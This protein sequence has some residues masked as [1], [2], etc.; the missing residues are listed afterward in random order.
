MKEKNLSEEFN[1]LLFLTGICYT[2][3]PVKGSYPLLEYGTHLI[4]NIIDFVAKEHEKLG[5]KNVRFNILIPL[6]LLE[7]MKDFY[8]KFAPEAFV[9][10]ET[11]KGQKF[12][13]PLVL[14]ATSEIPMYHTYSKIIRSYRD[15]P[16]K[17]YQIVP[18]FRCETKMTRPL[19]R[20]REIQ[21][22][23]EAHAFF[24]N[25]DQAMEEFDKA[26]DLYKRIYEYFNIPYIM[27]DL[28]EKETFAG[29]N[30]TVDFKVILPDG[31]L[32]ELSSTIDL[33]YKYSKVYEVKFLDRENKER[34]VYQICFGIG[35][36][37]VLGTLLFLGMDSIGFF[38]PPTVCRMVPIIPITKPEN[39][40]KIIKYCEEIKKAFEE[41]GFEALIDLT[42]ETPG[43]KFYA[44]DMK[45]VPFKIV[46]GEKELESQ[47]VMVSFRTKD[48]KEIKQ[49]EL[50]DKIN[51]VLD[52]INSKHRELMM[53]K[54]QELLS[55]VVVL[56][57]VDDPEKKAEELGLNYIGQIMDCNFNKEIIGKHLFAKEI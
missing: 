7:K 13:E 4:N 57:N 1:K 23:K 38:L 3:Y 21:H 42:D 45:G 48:K 16:V 22:F 35:L 43:S 47:T 40:E 6:S 10:K 32:L 54:G 25:Q 8:E 49:N 33:E 19:F 12:D 56:D 5:Y 51:E 44:W 29:S 14:R 15:L 53:K 24:E 17:I 34:Y 50:K 28:P 36:D 2:E 18:V 55:K 46:I 9:V 11:L 20:L 37:R 52:F 39:Q 41:L 26:I 27:V 30:R 31:K